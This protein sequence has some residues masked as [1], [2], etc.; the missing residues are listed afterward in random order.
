MTASTQ[1]VRITDE[2]WDRHKDVLLSLYLAEDSNNTLDDLATIMREKYGF[3]ASTSQIE[4]RLK[5]WNARKNLKAEEWKPILDRLDKIPRDTR[6]RVVISGRVVP[7]R[8]IIRA[9]RYNKHKLRQTEDAFSTSNSLQIPALPHTVHIELMGLDGRWTRVSDGN[10]ITTTENSIPSR[11]RTVRD[12]LN[13]SEDPGIFPNSIRMS[14]NVN[15]TERSTF[16]EQ[17]DIALNKAMAPEHSPIPRMVVNS[18]FSWLHDLPSKALL[19]ILASNTAEE[20]SSLYVPEDFAV[21]YTQTFH[22]MKIEDLTLNTISSMRLWTLTEKPQIESDQNSSLVSTNGSGTS[23]VTW[24]L[25]YAVINGFSVLESI[26]IDLLPGPI[27]PNKDLPLLSSYLREA[28]R[29]L[30]TVLALGFFRAAVQQ[31]QSNLVAQILDTGLVD[32]NKAIIV[33]SRLRRT[34]LEAAAIKGDHITMGILLDH[35]ADASQ[36]RGDDFPNLLCIVLSSLPSSSQ[37]IG[38]QPINLI[39]KLAE[40]GAIVDRNVLDAFDH[41]ASQSLEVS[42]SLAPC[43]TSHVLSFEDSDLFGSRFWNRTLYRV[44]EDVQAAEFVHNTFS[45]CMKRHGGTC[46]QRSQRHIDQSLLAA[47]SN[48]YVKTFQVIL[49]YSAVPFDLSDGRLLSAAIRGGNPQLIGFVMARRPDINAQPCDLDGNGNSTTPLAEAIRTN[50]QALVNGFIEAG[51]LASLHEGDRFGVALEAAVELGNAEQVEVLLRHCQNLE[52]QNVGNALLYA[53]R[54]KSEA[55][56]DILVHAGAALSCSPSHGSAIIAAIKHGNMALIHTLLRTGLATP[57]DYTHNDD[58]II[59]KAIE[60]GD[61]AVVQN[62]LT[63]FDIPQRF[64]VQLPQS[65]D[66]EQTHSFWEEYKAVPWLIFLK[67][68][69]NDSNM[70]Q[71]LLKSKLVTADFLNVSLVLAFVQ[72]DEGVIKSLVEAGADVTDETV[73]KLVAKWKPD[74]FRGLMEMRRNKLVVT[75]GW[76]T[77]VFKN[78]IEQGLSIDSIDGLFKPE[79][80][81]FLDT[82]R[83]D[84]RKPALTPLGVAILKS[85]DFPQLGYD[86]VAMLLSSGCDPGGLVEWN[87]QSNAYTNQTALLKAIEVGNKDII[88]LL[89]GAGANVN[90][91]TENYCFIKRSPLQKAAEIGSLEIIQLLLDHGANINSPPAFS[92]GGTALQLAAMTGNCY[93]VAEL[94]SHGARLHMA[95]SKIHGRWPI[96]GAAEHGRLDMIQFLW[97][98]NSKSVS[99]YSH[100]SE[101]G[102]Q[103]KHLRKAMRLA[104]ENGHLACRDLIAELSGLPVTATD[105]PAVVS[106][107]YIDWPLPGLAIE[108]TTAGF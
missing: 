5:V 77:A 1:S 57:R 94:L 12:M 73:Q 72:E 89:I 68:A 66:H 69:L 63:A 96:E 33:G 86:I 48:S 79:T 76:K 62:I 90:S 102:F 88:Q 107:M 11:S 37:T 52:T 108:S 39:R 59:W 20:M 61:I 55:L 19:D 51:I 46:I 8:R 36:T 81:D 16:S 71:L 44:V 75:R 3:I 95:P 103:E 40:A 41:L 10:L 31:G 85:K 47:A 38:V 9:R 25:S 80:T 106:P 56:I 49:P 34:P 64:T 27:N 60:S 84:T 91:W 17:H 45:N 6:S 82:G 35:G 50:N 42:R 70:L 67:K 15:P 26:P 18:P 23:K 97:S 22:H 24:I 53:I 2:Q 74:M 100:E 98:A 29:P 101:T 30:A 65:Q 43:I 78:A 99:T 54:A 4:A 13:S 87:S 104:T 21:G 32:V 93:L 92:H 28:P 58:M 105:V 83:C 7:Q 14:N